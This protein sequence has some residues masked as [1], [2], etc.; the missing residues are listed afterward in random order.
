M[1]PSMSVAARKCESKGHTG[2]VLS[3]HAVVADPLSPL[4]RATLGVAAARRA[5]E[6]VE[7]RATRENILIRVAEDT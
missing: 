6:S 2:S 3:Q 5:R 1:V 7:K 4:L